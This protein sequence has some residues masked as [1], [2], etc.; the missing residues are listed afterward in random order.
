MGLRPA[1]VCS[2]L[3]ALSQIA[4]G[5]VKVAV[6]NLQDAVFKSAE[7]LKADSEMQAKYKPRQD[8]I[9]RVTTEGTDL[10]AKYQAGQGK[11]TEIALADLQAQIQRKQRDLQRLQEDLNG[12][13]ER[14]RN[15]I[16]TK[17]S[18]K[19][20]DVVKKLADEKGL[21][22]VVDTST[23]LFFK[24]ALDLTTDAIAAYNKAYPVEAAP[25]NPAAAPAKPAA[26][27]AGK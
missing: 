18:Q 20:G 11:M 5:Q 8:E 2:A 19:M 15:E 3:F 14:E 27:P 23:T 26:A 22:L 16:L 12:D 21:D 25:A 6:V 4:S 24:P 10:V 1:A 13:V 9:N 7:I 17:A